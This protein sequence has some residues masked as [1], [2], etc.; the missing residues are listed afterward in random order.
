MTQCL[1]HS[2]WS[3]CTYL[4]YKILKISL[5]YLNALGN[6]CFHATFFSLVVCCNNKHWRWIPNA[7]CA[8][9]CAALYLLAFLQFCFASN[10]YHHHHF[11]H[12]IINSQSCYIQRKQFLKSGQSKPVS[13]IVGFNFSYLYFVFFFI[14]YIYSVLG[15]YGFLMLE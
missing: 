14:F 9:C 11:W 4:Q 2:R 7:C 12:I 5:T 3:F 6:V 1:K 15:V 13:L 10:D 8:C